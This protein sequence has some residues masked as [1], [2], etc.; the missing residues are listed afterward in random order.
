MAK[1]K[2]Q[3]NKQWFTKHYSLFVENGVIIRILNYRPWQ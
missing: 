3:E 2:G 1:R